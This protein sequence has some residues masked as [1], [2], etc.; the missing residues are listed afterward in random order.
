[1]CRGFTIIELLI[2]FG[3]GLIVLLLLSTIVLSIAC[4]FHNVPGQTFTVTGKERVQKNDDSKYLV[5]TDQT[6]YEVTDSWIHGRWSSSD[7][8]GKLVVGKTYTATLQG[9]RIPFF[10]MYPNIIEPKEVT[11]SSPKVEK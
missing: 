11:S 10:S 6:T 4:A 7:V 5:F 2:G 1:M 3:I 9:Y 8:Y